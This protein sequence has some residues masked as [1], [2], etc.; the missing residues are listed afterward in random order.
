MSNA[1]LRDQGE[2]VGRPALAEYL[3]GLPEEKR[4]EISAQ[5]LWSIATAASQSVGAIQHMGYVRGPG[6]L[7]L[8]LS[9]S[10]HSR[11]TVTR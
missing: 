3:R 4:Q 7:G 8:Y 2:K 6:A 11:M 1:V 5:G 10:R 9:P